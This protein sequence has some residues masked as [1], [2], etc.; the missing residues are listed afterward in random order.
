MSIFGIGIDLCE[1][2]RIEESLE[3]HGERFARKVLNSNELEIMAKQKFKA[4]YLAKR[5]AAKE[6]FAKAMGTGI[7]DGLILP[8]IEVYSDQAGKPHIR[9]HGKAAEKLNELGD[10]VVHLSISDEKETAI[11]Q[12][13][14][15]RRV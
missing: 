14:I 4:R 6:A 15:E 1:I 12:V 8:D 11:A 7:A 3:R 9:L 2:E 13:V 5:F 10:M